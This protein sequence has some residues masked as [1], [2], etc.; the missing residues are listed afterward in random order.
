MSIL[1]LKNAVTERPQH[2]CLM[3][4]DLYGPEQTV[5]GTITELGS[6]ITEEMGHQHC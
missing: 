3:L 1:H 5:G 6:L 2:H 4:V